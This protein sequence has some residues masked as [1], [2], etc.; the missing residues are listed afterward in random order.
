MLN[1]RPSSE[2]RALLA[3]VKESSGRGRDRTA[4]TIKFYTIPTEYNTPTSLFFSPPHLTFLLTT[5][6][7][8]SPLLS[9][10]LPH[11]LLSSLQALA[12]QGLHGDAIAELH[13]VLSM[14][15][16]DV[17]EVTRVKTTCFIEII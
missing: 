17:A 8:T 16:L 13:L 2:I 15:P 12:A 11:P 7:H 5:T 14:Q 1:K 6:Q 9:L 4:L 3:K 10:P